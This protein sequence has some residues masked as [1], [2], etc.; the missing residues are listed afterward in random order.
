ME[1]VGSYRCAVGLFVNKTF[2]MLCCLLNSDFTEWLVLFVI[3]VHALI[4]RMFIVL[5]W[6]S[7]TIHP[8]T[9]HIWNSECANKCHFKSYYL[10][11]NSTMNK[12]KM[13]TTISKLLPVKICE[14]ITKFMAKIKLCSWN[15][16][17][18]CHAKLWNLIEQ[19]FNKFMYHVEFLLVLFVVPFDSL[20]INFSVVV[21]LY[22]SK[23]FPPPII[24]IKAFSSTSFIRI[25]SLTTHSILVVL[26]IINRQHIKFHTKKREEKK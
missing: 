15:A 7:T 26:P 5:F 25:Q 11:Q 21:S 19:K 24:H 22:D 9:E 13:Y 10:M 6:I 3:H 2:E 1:Y 12:T 8:N 23:S 14:R 16:E 20:P 17:L 4:P 18:I